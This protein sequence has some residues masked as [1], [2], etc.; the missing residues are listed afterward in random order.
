MFVI[1]LEFQ[2]SCEMKLLAALVVAASCV[3]ACRGSAA[4]NTEEDE[5]ALGNQFDVTFLLKLPWTNDL[6]VVFGYSR[7]PDNPKEQE[8]PSPKS[9]NVESEN[10]DLNPKEV[11]PMS[12]DTKEAKPLPYDPK[13]AESKSRDIPK[14]STSSPREFKPPTI[15]FPPE[16]TLLHQRRFLFTVLGLVVVIGLACIIAQK[17]QQKVKWQ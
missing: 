13:A 3:G 9:I 17:R 10:T 14:K 6:E 8:T 7:D 12:S 1:S 5:E 15:E 2:V 4:R 16:A 11:T